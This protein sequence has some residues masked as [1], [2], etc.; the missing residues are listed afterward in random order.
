M[1]QPD[2]R[3]PAGTDTAVPEVDRI[4]AMIRQPWIRLSVMSDDVVVTDRIAGGA[5]PGSQL[6]RAA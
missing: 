6:D 1:S 4:G 3:S 2:H 5:A